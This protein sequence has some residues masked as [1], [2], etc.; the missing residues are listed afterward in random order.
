MIYL[1]R[2]LLSLIL[3]LLLISCAPKS[4]YERLVANELKTGERND[5]LFL[6]Y[7]FGMERPVFFEHSWQLNQQEIIKGGGHIIYDLEELSFPAQKTFYP[8]FHNNRIYSIPI[9][10]S[11]RAW[12]PWNEELQ[13]DQL[14][15]ELVTFYEQ[16]YGGE[17]INLYHPEF[18][19]HVLVKIDYNRQIT[20]RREDEMYAQ[21]EFK[22]LS[23][24]IE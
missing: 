13:S 21:V 9:R 3:F 4:D 11:Y 22:D 20:I 12:S 23:V 19:E 1:S 17:F 8:K 10:I 18:E 5:S 15:R 2:K 14:I 24:I 6:G 7:E 16:Q